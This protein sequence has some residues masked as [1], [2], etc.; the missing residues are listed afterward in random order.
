MSVFKFSSRIIGSSDPNRSTLAGLLGNKRL[1]RVLIG[2]CLCLI[3][4]HQHMLWRLVDRLRCHFTTSS[5]LKRH[6]GL[7]RVLKSTLWFLDPKVEFISGAPWRIRNHHP[8]T[9]F[10]L[11][12][13][14]NQW[15]GVM[16]AV[17]GRWESRGGL[18]WSRALPRVP[19]G[20]WM[21]KQEV[22]QESEATEGRRAAALPPR[23]GGSW[24]GVPRQKAIGGKQVAKLRA[25]QTHARFL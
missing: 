1:D 13:H 6:L 18:R 24:G 16:R 11:S 22:I 14:I 12:E 15:L 21:R 19:A 3:I 7:K 23:W 10:H 9:L 5:R 20:R 2:S 25:E 17:T 4:T 8:S